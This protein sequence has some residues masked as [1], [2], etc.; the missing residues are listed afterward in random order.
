[1]AT[2]LELRKLTSVGHCIDMDTPFPEMLRTLTQLSGGKGKHGITCS[3]PLT[4]VGR[5]S[6]DPWLV[7]HTVPMT[8][9]IRDVLAELRNSA[10][11]TRDQGDK[12]AP[13]RGRAGLCHITMQT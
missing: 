13:R 12:F 9:S 7:R 6:R 2:G 4:R 8:G 1:M 11:D 3:R 5:G 10:L